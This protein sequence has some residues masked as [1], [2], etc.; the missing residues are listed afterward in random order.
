[1]SLDTFIRLADILIEFESDLNLKQLPLGSVHCLAIHRDEIKCTWK[2]AKIAYET[3]LEEYEIEKSEKLADQSD[4]DSKEDK[5]STDDKESKDDNESKDVK[6]STD[7]KAPKKVEKRKVDEKLQSV[8]AKYKATYTIYCNCQVIGEIQDQLSSKVS[9]S[10]LEGNGFKLPSCDIPTFFEDYLSWPTF[11]DN[12]VAAFIKS[13]LSPVQKLMHLRQKTKN[14]AFDIVSKAPLEDSGFDIAWSA[15][16]SRYE[17]KRILVNGQ[18]RKLFEI[19]PI[20]IE[21]S[22]VLESFQRDINSVLSNLKSYEISI[23]SWDPILVYFCSSRLPEITLTLWEHTLKDKTAIPTWKS[24]DNFLTNRYR[25]LE[26]VAETRNSNSS[27][28][29]SKARVD[30]SFQQKQNHIKTFQTKVKGPIC[31]LCPNQNHIIRFCPKFNLMIP[32]NRFHEIKKQK[33]CINCFSKTHSVANCTSKYVCSKCSKKHHTLLHLGSS[34][35]VPL[36]PNS[37]PF[38]SNVEVQSTRI[39]NHYCSNSKGVLLGTAMVDIC[40]LGSRYR[41]IALIDSGRKATLFRRSCLIDLNCHILES[42]PKCTAKSTRG[43]TSKKIYLFSVIAFCYSV[44]EVSGS[45][46]ITK[47]IH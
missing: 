27:N 22:T 10:P 25:T 28:V 34:T 20:S 24:L 9:A 40:S 3:F 13:T 37:Q 4:K 7:V 47:F 33:L 12:F 21:S 17:N 23:S 6:E 5:V 26:S 43:D 19:K 29:T 8:K 38:V 45:V 44:S 30:L 39:Q 15:L 32:E 41:V 35:P 2:K 14:D 16:K 31:P 42:M 18:L 1:M 11:R 36:N 46:I